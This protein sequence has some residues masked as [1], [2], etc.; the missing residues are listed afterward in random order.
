MP[1]HL[2]VL[3]LMEQ[4]RRDRDVTDARLWVALL[5]LIDVAGSDDHTAARSTAVAALEGQTVFGQPAADLDEPYLSL[6]RKIVTDWK[7]RILDTDHA[8]P[9]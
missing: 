8:Q 2:A 9:S 4:Q 6:F 1:S 3:D 5:A 7:G